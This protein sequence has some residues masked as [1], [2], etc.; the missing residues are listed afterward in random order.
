MVEKGVKARKNGADIG[1][2]GCEWGGFPVVN[3]SAREIGPEFDKFDMGLW[4]MKKP[5][6]REFRKK[7][8]EGGGVVSEVAR[9]LNV[10][11]PTVYAWRDHYKM[12]GEFLKA[13][14]E[15][16]Q[17]CEDVFY[18]RLMHED[19]DKRYEAATFGLRH[20]RD[21]GRFGNIS[22]EMLE[23]LAQVAARGID[24]RVV[25]GHLQGYLDAHTNGDGDS[26]KHS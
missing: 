24:L 19:E 3:T 22:R 20:L 16:R 7:I 9:L 8:H 1:I 25:A 15:L 21:D 23:V 26:V 2:M 13:R 10:S 4:A 14:H 6:K 12:H 5:G 18:E 17:L 11:R